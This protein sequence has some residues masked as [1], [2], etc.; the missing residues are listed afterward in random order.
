[1]RG[2]APVE[3]SE[4]YALDFAAGLVRAMDGE[5]D[6]RCLLVCLRCV[7]ALLSAPFAAL[8]APL[9][10]ELF[11]VTACYFPITFTPPANDPHGI[12]REQL[13]LAGVANCPSCSGAE[14]VPIVSAMSFT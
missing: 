6:P 5:K 10:N 13:S 4:P 14:P 9:S 7:A 3:A 12:T 11:D 8:T 1:M 2:G